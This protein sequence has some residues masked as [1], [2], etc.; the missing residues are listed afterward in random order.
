MTAGTLR[1]GHR[2]AIHPRRQDAPRRAGSTAQGV[3]IRQDERRDDKGRDA[4]AGSAMPPSGGPVCR[5]RAGG[6]D[7]P[8]VTVRGAV[9]PQ[10][11]QPGALLDAH[12][13]HHD[14]L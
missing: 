13:P 7:Q 5:R 4:S 10:G 6:T 11:I 3:Q 2:P 14:G 12:H 9:A 1:A 8:G